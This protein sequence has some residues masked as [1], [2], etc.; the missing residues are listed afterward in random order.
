MRTAL[1]CIAKNEDHYID[2]WI[3]YHL[4]LGFDDV[5]IYQNDWT[6]HLNQERESVHLIDVNGEGQ[7]MNSYMDFIWNRSTD[8]DFA[9]FFDV[10]EFLCFKP[11]HEMDL[12]KFLKDFEDVYCIGINWRFF[13]D[14]GLEKV[15]NNEYSLLKRFKKA[16]ATQN[17]HIKSIFNLKMYREKKLIHSLA[18]Q[19]PHCFRNS[20][21]GKFCIS[22][23]R[24]HFIAGPFNEN[25]DPTVQLNHYYCKTKEE[26]LTI[27]NIRGRGDVPTSSGFKFYSIK[28]F[29]DKNKN[30]IED[31]AAFDF[32]F[33]KS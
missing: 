16:E 8:F 25:F 32:F 19:N 30:E 21:F 9:A 10:D 12:K 13:G 7:Q 26:F 27:K 33:G 6:A 22:T 17:K 14:S 18:M 23:D 5:F 1:V 28:D 11:P 29:E 31:T 15:E 2:E 24:S 20:Y 4:K 3:D